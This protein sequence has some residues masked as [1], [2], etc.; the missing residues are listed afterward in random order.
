MTVYVLFCAQG[1]TQ[2][3]YTKRLPPCFKNELQISV[4]SVLSSVVIS[5]ITTYQLVTFFYVMFIFQI[6]LHF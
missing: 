6:V 2:M 3:Y 5:V 4:R 1:A